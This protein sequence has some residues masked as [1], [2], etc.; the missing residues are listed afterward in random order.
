MEGAHAAQ[1]HVE[2]GVGIKDDK[3]SLQV[4]K[5]IE[6]GARGTKR[7]RLAVVCDLNVPLAT[8]AAVSL[9][10]VGAKASEQQNFID[11]IGFG[12][13]NLMLEQRLSTNV[14]QRLWQ[15]PTV[16]PLRRSALPPGNNDGLC[17]LSSGLKCSKLFAYFSNSALNRLLPM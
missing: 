6:H 1:V 3:V 13:Q 4:R 9:N 11:S 10:G 7:L 15:D 8:V 17:I 12:D 2:H 5:S 14:H 16:S